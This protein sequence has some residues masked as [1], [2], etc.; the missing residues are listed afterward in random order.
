MS[1]Y[2]Y[3]NLS[4]NFGVP[5]RYLAPAWPVGLPSFRCFDI[6]SLS[7]FTQNCMSNRPLALPPPLPT[8]LTLLGHFGELCG[9]ATV[10]ER[11][12]MIAAKCFGSCSHSKLCPSMYTMYLFK[13]CPWLH[14]PEQALQYLIE[15]IQLLG[16]A[17]CDVVAVD[18]SHRVRLKAVQ[19]LGGI[20]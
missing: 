10:L 18:C 17:F 4:M 16:L 20:P 11:F 6:I 7:L 8:R 3:R 14:C 5:T 12:L 9:L 13:Y 15:T 2:S 1:L 19:K